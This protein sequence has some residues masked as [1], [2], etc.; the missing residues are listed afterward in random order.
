MSGLCG[1][2][3][4]RKHTRELPHP[5]MTCRAGFDPDQAGCQQPELRKDIR[6]A[7]RASENA[8]ADPVNTVNLKD[9]LAMPEPI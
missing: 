3:D 6:A 8:C 9:C 4:G 5:V 2:H 1:R 7:Q